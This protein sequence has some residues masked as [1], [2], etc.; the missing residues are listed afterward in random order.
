MALMVAETM[1]QRL[2]GIC[3]LYQVL[4][5]LERDIF[6]PEQL[7][8]FVAGQSQKIAIDP[9]NLPQVVCDYGRH[10]SLTE[11]LQ[12]RAEKSLYCA[13]PHR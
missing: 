5:A 9:F 1:F 10:L 2:L 8:S 4:N 11:H 13:L 12:N 3:Y 7:L 6:F